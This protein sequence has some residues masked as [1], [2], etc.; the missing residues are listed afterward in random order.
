MRILENAG[1]QVTT[2]VDPAGALQAITQGSLPIDVLLTDFNM[3]KMT[4]V[5]LIRGALRSEYPPAGVGLM[6]GVLMDVGDDVELELVLQ[7][8]HFFDKP[9]E[10]QELSSWVDECMGTTVPLAE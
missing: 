6:S 3:P 10:A 8:V 9:F 2:M 1:H 7:G 5:E 4:G